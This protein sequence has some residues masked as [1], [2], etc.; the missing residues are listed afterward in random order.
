MTGTVDVVGH[1][2]VG[3]VAGDRVL[4]EP[5]F[6]CGTCWYCRSGRYSLCEHLAVGACQADLAMADAFTLSP[7][8]LHRI[9]VGM[10]DA[11]A[12]LR[13][14]LSTA[15]HGDPASWRAPGRRYSRARRG[16]YR[17]ADAPLCPQCS[18]RHSRCHASPGFQAR[19]SIASWSSRRA[20]PTQHDTLAHLPALSQLLVNE[21]AY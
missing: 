6:V 4:L 16:H 2:A 5:N 1:G 3:F 11:T 12:A 19:T 10:S 13:E 9:P 18:G 14:R 7:D 21:T 17:P 20:R 15:T 8:R